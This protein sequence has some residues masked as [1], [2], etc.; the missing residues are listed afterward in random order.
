MPPQKKIK[1]DDNHVVWTGDEVKM[2]LETTR[3]FKVGKAYGGINRERMKKN[4]EKIREKFVSNLL[5]AEDEMSPHPASV[6]TR[7]CIASE[8]K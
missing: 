3:D 4:C 6:F 2:L 8:I 5:P 7:D 1:T